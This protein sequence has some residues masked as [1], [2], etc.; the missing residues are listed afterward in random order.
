MDRGREYGGRKADKSDDD[1]IVFNL[2]ALA[3]QRAGLA[4]DDFRQGGATR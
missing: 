4:A 1:G 3:W 2:S